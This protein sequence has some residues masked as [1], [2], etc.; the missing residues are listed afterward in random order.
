MSGGGA[1]CE[2]RGERHLLS[3]PVGRPKPEDFALVEAEIR[4]PGEGQVLSWRGVRGAGR[5][6][7]IA[8]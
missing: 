2:S 6:V 4:Q 1:G 3:R 7:R 8:A 5:G